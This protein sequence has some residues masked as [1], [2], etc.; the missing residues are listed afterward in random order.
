MQ[1]KDEIS[2]NQAFDELEKILEEIEN[3][4]I[5]LDNLSN[6]IKRA[7]FLLKSCKSKLRSAEKEINGIIEEIDQED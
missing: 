4:E 5:D 6:K 2:Y 1:K 7:S 3:E